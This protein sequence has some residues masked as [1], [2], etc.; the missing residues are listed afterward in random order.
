METIV[1]KKSEL[2]PTLLQI[3]AYSNKKENAGM[4]VGGLLSE[5]I[6]LGTKRVLQKIH[7]GIH[8]EYE[9]FIKDR[10]EIFKTPLIKTPLK[11]AKDQIKETDVTKEG[12]IDGLE[13]EVDGEVEELTQEQRQKM[14][15]ELMKENER[16]QKE[17]NE[18]LDE[19]VKILCEKVLISK[20]LD[21][22][23]EANY[24]FELI[25]KIG[26]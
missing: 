21:I 8:K 5:N 15:E 6:T 2:L 25:E 1:L 17:L 3:A 7:K 4:L 16:L 19:E 23:T 22:Q 12:E 20:L 14:D 9:Q 13:G 24:D 10:E 11:G 18:L 26:K